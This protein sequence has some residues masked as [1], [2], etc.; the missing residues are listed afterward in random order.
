MKYFNGLL[1]R[2]YGQAPRVVPRLASRFAKDL[3]PAAMGRPPDPPVLE[4]QDGLAGEPT[5]PRPDRPPPD[6]PLLERQDGLAEE[7]ARPL[8]DRSPPLAQR[9]GGEPQQTG[10]DGGS[11]QRVA[12]SAY[13][14]LPPRQPQT[15][16]QRPVG[17]ATDIVGRL[18]TG[19]G[20]AADPFQSAEPASA[21]QRSTAAAAPGDSKLVPTLETTAEP[22]PRRGAPG[23]QPL[24]GQTGDLPGTV[25]LAPAQDDSA[26]QKAAAPSAAGAA[27]PL[28]A[29]RSAELPANGR[30]AD[31][32]YAPE[33]RQAADAHQAHDGSSTAPRR[34]AAETG[35]PA[36]S[37]AIQVRIG[38]IEVRAVAP[39]TPAS[40]TAAQQPKPALALADYLAR[41]KGGAR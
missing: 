6:S 20:G 18:G 16:P 9:A 30:A 7:A 29:R 15:L 10:R 5:S 39:P 32:A 26:T 1:D 37:P 31:S 4:R 34:T 40:P 11:Q 35:P 19:R 27:H 24:G 23:P 3:G 22:M 14:A 36:T 28:A 33:R 25:G 13:R 17:T 38:R 41:P 12:A 21:M 8:L 2:V